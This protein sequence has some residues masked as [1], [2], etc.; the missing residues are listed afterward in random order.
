[1]HSTG[2][3]G[4]KFSTVLNESAAALAVLRCY[5]R[6]E[7]SY[8]EKKGAAGARGSLLPDF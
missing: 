6:D 2:E 3:P 4:F 5:T 7:V 8:G 1:M